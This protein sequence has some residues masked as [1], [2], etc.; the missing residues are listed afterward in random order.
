MY[1]FVAFAC[2]PFLVWTVAFRSTTYIYSDYTILIGNCHV[3]VRTAPEGA[4]MARCTIDAE[5]I[6]YERLVATTKRWK[7]P[8]GSTGRYVYLLFEDTTSSPKLGEV[9]VY[10]AT[11]A[12][13]SV[14]SSKY[15]TYQLSCLANVRFEIPP[16]IFNIYN[17]IYFT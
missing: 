16:I 15:V 5:T 12:S 6:S 7:C 8:P 3:D 9:E 10:A 4:T 11:A 1:S 17:C 14:A 2:S 13:S